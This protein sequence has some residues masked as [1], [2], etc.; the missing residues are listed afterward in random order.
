MK[1][2]A[3]VATWL[4]LTGVLTGCTTQTRWVGGSG[5]PF[6]QDNYVCEQNA[7]AMHPGYTGFLDLLSRTGLGVVH[8]GQR[9]ASGE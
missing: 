8:D 1:A 3:T 4:L 9:L 7:W 2:T 5:R 6:A